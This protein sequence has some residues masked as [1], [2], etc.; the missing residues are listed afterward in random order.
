MANHIT[1]EQGIAKIK[2]TLTRDELLRFGY[3][4]FVVARLVWDYADTIID[5]CIQMRLTETRRLSRAVRQLK[6][7]YDRM[8]LPYIDK[9]HKD[10]EADNMFTIEDSLKDNTRLYFTNLKCQVKSEY[11]ELTTDY[12]SLIFATYQCRVMLKALLVYAE[13]QRVYVAEKMGWVLKSILP[14]SVKA[15]E[16]IIIEFAGDKQLSQ[17]WDKTEETFVKTFA[18]QIGLIKLTNNAPEK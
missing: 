18:T 14:N 1:R 8:R 13:R 9:Q 4:P 10:N 2:S 16:P 3:V 6:A 15:L 12:Q 17:E 5:I 7:E 11:P